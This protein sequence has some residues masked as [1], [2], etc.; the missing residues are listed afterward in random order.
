[1][2]PP[3]LLDENLEHEVLHRLRNYGQD[4]EHVDFHDQLQKGEEDQTLAQYSLQHGILLVTYDDDFEDHHDESE[5]WGV[6]FFTD[7]DWAATDVAD[8]IHRILDFYPPSELQQMNV[9]GRE[10]L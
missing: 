4:V 1:M 7:N 3:L 5:Y 6:L 2:P 8:T 10:W 9:V